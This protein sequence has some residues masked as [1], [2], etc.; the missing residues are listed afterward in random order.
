MIHILYL[1]YKF[2][3]KYRYNSD[4][5]ILLMIKWQHLLFTWSS[6]TTKKKTT[7]KTKTKQN[8]LLQRFPVFLYVNLWRS[9][10]ILL[11]LKMNIYNM[12]C[13]KRFKKNSAMLTTKYCFALH[14]KHKILLCVPN[15]NPQIAFTWITQ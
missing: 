5:K 11:V 15:K 4:V 13:L 2:V 6:H 3:N 10:Q 14:C 1:F 7:Q 12:K 8:N 9:C